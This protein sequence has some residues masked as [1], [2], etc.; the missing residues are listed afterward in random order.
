MTVE[1][2]PENQRSYYDGII[3][4]RLANEP[5]RV[6]VVTVN[7]NVHYSLQPRQHE[8]FQLT[9]LTVPPPD[10][11][12]YPQH[13]G[14]G[15]AAGGGKSYLARAVGTAACMMWPGCT[16][17]IFRK[18][19]PELRENHVVKYLAELPDYEGRFYKF[20]KNDYI[21]EF[22][23]GSRFLFGYL[24]HDDDVYRYQGPEYDFMLFEE[25]THQT[26]FQVNWLTSNRLRATVP[27]SRPF[28]MYLSNPGNI[29]HQWFKRIFISRN[30]NRSQEEYPEN[31]TF[32]Q[33][34]VWDNYHLMRNDPAYVR[35]LLGQPEPFRSWYLLGDWEAGAG[36][37]LSEL[38][39]DEHLI[40]PFDIPQHWVMFGAFDWGFG[41]P[42]SFGWYAVN[43]D[44]RVFKVDTVRGRGMHE[45]EIAERI[46]SRVPVDRLRYIVAGHDL[47]HSQEHARGKGAPTRAEIFALHRILCR[48]ADVDRKQGLNNMR[49]YLQWRHGGFNGGP[50]TPDFVMFDTP[51]NRHCFD[52]L[53]SMVTDPD[54]MED[55]LKVDADQM[56]VGGDDPYDETRYALNSRP[57]KAKGTFD[58]GHEVT[59][60]SPETLA[61]EA[62]QKRKGVFPGNRRMIGKRAKKD[63]II[64]PEFGGML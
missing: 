58:S 44:G 20:N 4:N 52:N 53:E 61:Y 17:I 42:W 60:W 35:R 6:P 15:G 26:W 11:G 3:A 36:M 56:G 9:P 2:A 16:G 8:A 62:E 5:P 63:V 18:T 37:A 57:H 10:K 59:A 49:L 55:V 48:Y 32:L 64:H 33:A 38:N 29:G 31:Y 28:V 22:A 13:I 23:N 24:R 41:H 27:M 46:W 21:A 19:K 45:S 30:Y 50:K 14:Y 7:K 47:W 40:E 12:D 39:R 1:V 54:D 34:K 43:E 25:A 51:G